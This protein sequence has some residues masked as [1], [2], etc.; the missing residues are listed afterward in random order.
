MPTPECKATDNAAY[1]SS[2]R[3][4]CLLLLGLGLLCV[5]L[6]CSELDRQRTY[7]T[8]AY[9]EKALAVASALTQ[10]SASAIDTEVDIF[11][12]VD[13]NRSSTTLHHITEM[14]GSSS[15]LERDIKDGSLATR[16]D[17]NNACTVRAFD[18]NPPHA[19]NIHEQDM[20]VIGVRAVSPSTE[21]TL[22]THSEPW[23][24]T[25][26]IFPEQC[27]HDSWIADPDFIILKYRREL[28][29]EAVHTAVVLPEVVL[30]RLGFPPVPFLSPQ[31]VLNGIISSSVVIA[32]PEQSRR[33]LEAGYGFMMAVD[34]RLI[35]ESVL[36]Q[37][38]SRANQ[39]FHAHELDDAIRSI[40]IRFVERRDVW[41]FKVDAATAAILIPF[42]ILALSTSL[43]FRVRRIDPDRDLMSEPWLMMAARGRWETLT[44]YSFV[45]LVLGS[46]IAAAVSAWVFESD[47]RASIRSAWRL[48]LFP[49]T[50]TYVDETPAY[51]RG[52][53]AVQSL[54]LSWLSW[55]L[56]ANAISAYA[57]VVSVARVRRLVRRNSPPR[58]GQ[59]FR[60][61]YRPIRKTLAAASSRIRS[62]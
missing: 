57:V 25:V 36:R 42:L 2:A 60:R 28:D 22:L 43:L 18:L 8:F 1:V 20:V 7:E 41:G 46:V 12:T 45:A 11:E 34:Y 54:L 50:D 33:L 19:A 53:E 61:I 14:V 24:T 37:A 15:V 26:V 49:V 16:A 17:P 62:S 47:A 9:V 40:L 38:E 5:Q 32:K 30:Q 56:A 59:A 35:Q 31:D 13:P 51:E 23:S 4:L 27:D 48:F 52:R 21:L 6:T 3:H 29:E 44:A 39:T 58:P 10:S 55:C